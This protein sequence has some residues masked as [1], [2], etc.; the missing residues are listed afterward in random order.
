MGET[1]AEASEA[2]EE[3]CTRERLNWRRNFVPRERAAAPTRGSN[4]GIT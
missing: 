4:G 3:L 1:P 2:K